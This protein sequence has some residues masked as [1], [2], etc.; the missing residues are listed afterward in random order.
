M[1]GKGRKKTSSKLISCYTLDFP[2]ASLSSWRAAAAAE[3]SLSPLSSSSHLSVSS[4]TRDTNQLCRPTLTPLSVTPGVQMAPA[5]RDGD[6]RP[7]RR[8]SSATHDLAAGRTRPAATLETHNN[9]TSQ[10]LSSSVTSR[11]P[12]P[13]SRDHNKLVR[14]VLAFL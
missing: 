14:R 5:T 8:R 3:L 11:A 9:V 12:I 7:R 1:E 2:I 10:G 4:W 6:D 13:I